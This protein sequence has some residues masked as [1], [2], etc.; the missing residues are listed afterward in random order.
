MRR[1]LLGLIEGKPARAPSANGA[2]VHQGGVS[3]GLKRLIP[4]GLKSATLPVTTVIPCTKAVAA[5][6]SGNGHG[7]NPAC[8]DS[9]GML[10]L[11]VNGGNRYRHQPHHQAQDGHGGIQMPERRLST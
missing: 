8:L 11:Q 2:D 1:R 3:H 9:V 4:A 7:I 5:I 10:L 6:K